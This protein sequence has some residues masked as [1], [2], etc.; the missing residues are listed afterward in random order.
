MVDIFRNRYLKDIHFVILD[1][2]RFCFLMKCKLKITLADRLYLL[3]NIISIIF[4]LY[5]H[6]ISVIF[7]YSNLNFDVEKEKYAST[8]PYTYPQ[9]THT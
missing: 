5:F 9:R 1:R 2:C 8:N 7:Y 4:Q 6:N 3:R